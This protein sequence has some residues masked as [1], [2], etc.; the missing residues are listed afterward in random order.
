MGRHQGR[1]QV[2]GGQRVRLEAGRLAAAPSAG[3]ELVATALQGIGLSVANMRRLHDRPEQQLDAER[4]R[5]AADR[6]RAG[7]PGLYYHVDRR[8]APTQWR[9]RPS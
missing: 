2:P 3:V 6:L 1:G 9:W 4:A 8:P 5:D 7:R